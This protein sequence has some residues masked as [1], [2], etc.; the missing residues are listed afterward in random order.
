M[1]ANNFILI[2]QIGNKYEVSHRDADTYDILWKMK[3][4]VSSVGEALLEADRIWNEIVSEGLPV[5]YGIRTD[6]ESDKKVIKG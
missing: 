1:S 4:V 2:K 3:K 6:L 5:E